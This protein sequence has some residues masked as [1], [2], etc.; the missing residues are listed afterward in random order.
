MASRGGPAVQTA[1]NRS[2][3]SRTVDI[4]TPFCAKVARVQELETSP[5]A[6]QMVDLTQ[7]TTKDHPYTAAIEAVTPQPNCS[8][9]RFT[10]IEEPVGSPYA[11]NMRDVPAPKSKVFGVDIGQQKCNPVKEKKKMP[12]KLAKRLGE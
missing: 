5:Y 11:A 9:A 7:P 8:L 10:S 1:A 4:A 2:F 3:E 12:A 6:A